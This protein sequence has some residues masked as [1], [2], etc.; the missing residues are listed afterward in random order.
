MYIYIYLSIYI[1]VYMSICTHIYVY[2]HI[3][4]CIYTHIYRYEYVHTDIWIYNTYMQVL[5]LMAGEGVGLSAGAKAA[6]VVHLLLTDSGHW[7]Q[8]SLSALCVCAYMSYMSALCVCGAP[9]A[10]RLRSL[11]PG[12]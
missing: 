9:L 4:T 7:L 12:L 3:Y 11:A 5:A 6:A 10:Y 1:H 2:I 8:V